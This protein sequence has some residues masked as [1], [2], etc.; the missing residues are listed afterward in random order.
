[1]LTPLAALYFQ[2]SPLGL[3]TL[4]FVGWL[5]SGTFPLFMGVI[6]GEAMSRR[7]AATAMGLVVCVGEVGGGFAI[8]SLAGHLGDLTGSLATPVLVQV[9][10]AA[11]GGVLCWFLVETA[12][13]KARAG[14]T[15]AATAA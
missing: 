12:P 11:I 9:V 6:P 15:Q 2:G 10:C 3:G 7:Q 8:T 4:M 13:V 1:V 5:A 14:A